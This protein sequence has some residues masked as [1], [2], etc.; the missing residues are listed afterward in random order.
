MRRIFSLLSHS[1]AFI[2]LTVL[3]Q[4]GGLVWLLSFLLSRLAFRRNKRRR[5][6]RKLGVFFFLYLIFTFL[7]VPPLARIWGR[8]PLPIIRNEHLKPLTLGTC[9][10]N[11]HYVKPQLLTLTQEVA[12]KLQ[13]THPGSIVSY[14]DA[15]FP[16]FDGFPLLPHLSHNDGRKL[17]LAFFYLDEFSKEEIH[18]SAPSMIGYGVFEG[19]QPGEVNTPE[20]C[21]KAGHWQYS[22]IQYIIWKRGGYEFDPERT[23]RL[24]NLFALQE[25]VHKVFIEPHL[26]ERLSLGNPKIRFHGCHAVRHDDHIHIEIS[27]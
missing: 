21:K 14:L 12:Q 26:K 18:S 10:L 9:L 13:K 15:N 17:D 25:S 23:R 11:R 19:P 24:I 1:L 16:F 20:K 7:L 6:F 3:T 8:V 4:I 22:L 27:R 5:W 2:L